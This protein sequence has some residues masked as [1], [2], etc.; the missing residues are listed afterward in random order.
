MLGHLKNTSFLPVVPASKVFVLNF[1]GDV[2]ATQ[3][4]KLREEI[5][6]VLDFGN[7]YYNIIVLPFH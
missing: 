4:N 6:A 3:V 2:M 7:L 5:T 1:E